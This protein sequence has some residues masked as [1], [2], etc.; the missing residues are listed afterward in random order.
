MPPIPAP[1]VPVTVVPQ[2]GFTGAPGATANAQAFHNVALKV[3]RDHPDLLASPGWAHLAT[4]V[5]AA[6]NRQGA[7]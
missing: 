1:S 4:Y 2:G 6:Q 7:P 3:A 5:H